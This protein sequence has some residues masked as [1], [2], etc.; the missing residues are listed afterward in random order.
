[1]KSNRRKLFLLIAG[2]IIGVA[3]I[4]T[5]VWLLKGE[6]MKSLS[7]ICIGLGAAALANV[8]GYLIN[9]NK[10]IKHPEMFRK[11]RIKTNDERN[12]IIR[13]KA[14]AK[15]HNILLWLMF[16]AI[17]VFIFFNAELYITLS[18]AGLIVV[19]FI[20]YLAYFNY[21]SKRM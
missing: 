19:Q 10:S 17:L 6:E 20:T 7:G 21:F 2:S 18:L 8:A 1:M 9:C 3:L 5:G 15:S 4:V 14:T 13:D 16:A 11:K 12:T